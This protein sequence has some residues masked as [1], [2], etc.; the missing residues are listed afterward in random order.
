MMNQ[1]L[2]PIEAIRERDVDI[3]LLEELSAD[4]DFCHWLIDEVGSPELK[5]R[6][7]AWRSISDHGLGETDLLFAYKSN[8]SAIYMMI[9][10]KLDAS[11]QSGQF[12]RYQ[13][14]GERYLQDGNCNAVY[15]VLI[16]P[17]IY[18]E[19]QNDFE[20][21]VTYESIV[22][23]FEKIGTERSM[24]KKELML[25]AIEKLRRGYR[26]VNS[27]PVQKFWHSYWKHKEETYPELKMKEPGI[28]PH[29]SDWPMLFDDRFPQVIFYHK[30]AQGNVD[31]TFKNDNKQIKKQLSKEVLP[32]DASIVEHSKRFSIRA[33]TGV[34]DRTKPFSEQV[35][36]VDKGL[37]T[38]VDLR[39]WLIKT[40]E[41]I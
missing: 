4:L 33:H 40:I 41:D 38:L 6:I 39:N 12:L 28:V 20:N 32:H 17:E 31:V 21:T 37:A 9:E 10:N 7:G 35:L 8:E 11:F 14:R 29:Q 16:A 25:I 2:L 3:I 18:C 36:L 1:G 19:N 26:P 30:L 15:H 23:R 34:I 13:K 27:E 22:E 24:F 5:E